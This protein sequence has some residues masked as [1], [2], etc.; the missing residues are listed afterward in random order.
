MKTMFRVWLVVLALSLQGQARADSVR[1][2]VAASGASVAAVSVVPASIVVVSAHVG[3]VMV[4]ES[5]R[6]VGDV[7]EVVFKG[8]VNASRAVVTVTAVSA[9]NTSIAIGQT[10]QVVAEGTGYLLVASGKVLCYVPGEAD[11]SLVRSTRSN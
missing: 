4:V 7:A 3:S 5:I 10:V 2:S 1:N 9:R 8:A 6:F 11:R